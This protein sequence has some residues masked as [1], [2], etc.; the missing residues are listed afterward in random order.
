MQLV[1]LNGNY[2]LLN[3]SLTKKKVA[4]IFSPGPLHPITLR[5]RG[6]GEALTSLN[7]ETSILIMWTVDG[8]GAVNLVNTAVALQAVT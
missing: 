2:Y 6:E 3:T 5:Q 4:R 1:L 7:V 8:C